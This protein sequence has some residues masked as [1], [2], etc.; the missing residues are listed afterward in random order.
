MTKLHTHQSGL[1]MV[2]VLVTLLI[3]SVGLL[4]LAGMQLKALQ[5]NHQAHLRTQ[6]T[7]LASD[8]LDRM[9]ANLP[10]TIDDK[11]SFID[12]RTETRTAKN[13]ATESC[14]V[15]EEMAIYDIRQWMSNIDNELPSGIGTIL[16][17]NGMATIQLMWDEDKKGISKSAATCDTYKCLSITTQII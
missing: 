6:A 15:P 13:C 5:Y 17:I 1:S 7:I 11:Y 16:Y 2:E 9:R 12:T 3:V 8:M 10:G 4:G 14:A